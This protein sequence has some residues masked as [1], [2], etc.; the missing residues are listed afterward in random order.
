[1]FAVKYFHWKG[2]GVPQT[3]V[4]LAEEA[5]AESDYC[6][7]QGDD[8]YFIQ[9]S[10]TECAEF[11]SKN[12]DY[13]TAQ[14]RAV[15]VSMDSNLNQFAVL[16]ELGSTGEKIPLSQPPD[17]SDTVTLTIIIMYYNFQS[18]G[19]MNSFMIAVILFLSETTIFMKSSIALR[20]L[21]LGS[22][23]S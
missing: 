23:N 5:S 3:L 8:D 20:L 21:F 17:M 7:F 1:M 16:T 14:G 6:A 18:I 9:S 19:S 12:P 11:L 10:L 15:L 22:L 4:K 2:L 13:R